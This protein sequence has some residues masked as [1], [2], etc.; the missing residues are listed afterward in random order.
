MRWAT[1]TGASALMAMPLDGIRLLDFSENVAGQYCS[2]MFCDYGAEVVLVEPPEGSATRRIGPFAPGDK[3]DSLI[4]FHLNCGK[5]SLALTPSDIAH[6]TL[7]SFAPRMDVVVLG[8]AS[9][10]YRAEIEAANPMAVIGIIDEFA[11]ESG[12][13]SWKGGELIVQAL[14]GMMHNNGQLGREPL[15]GVG[16]RSAY[17][18]GLVGYVGLTSALFSRRRINVG[19]VVTVDRAET[20]A[21]MAFPYVVQHLYNGEIR[22]RGDQTQSNGQVRCRDGWVCI[23]IYNHRFSAVCGVLGLPH[24]VDDPRFAT[25]RERQHNWSELFALVQDAARVWSADKLVAALQAA[26]VIAAKAPLPSELASDA[27]LKARDFWQSVQAGSSTRPALG[28]QF[29][30]SETPRLPPRAAPVLGEANAELLAQRP[31]AVT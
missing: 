3:Q 26:Q 4:F 22:S 16:H 5:R 12:F 21:A 19:Q 2:R 7:A 1:S 9:A 10:R 6:G 29:R 15:Y 20:A 14:S 8:G 31:G 13:A 17:A 28:P 27:H 24:L 18:A 25:S 23:W 30:M 11:S